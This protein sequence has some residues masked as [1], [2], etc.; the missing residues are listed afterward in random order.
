MMRMML[1][2]MTKQFN[3]LRRLTEHEFLIGQGENQFCVV[4]KVD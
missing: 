2:A 4:R 3:G 1:Q